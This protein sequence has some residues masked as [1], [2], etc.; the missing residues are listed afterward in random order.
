MGFC[1]TFFVASSARGAARL[2]HDMRVIYEGSIV[3]NVEF[4]YQ[5]TIKNFGLP[6]SIFAAQSGSPGINSDFGSP[7]KR[8]THEHIILT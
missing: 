1:W 5:T 7:D 3:I 2:M 4:D 6:E 8:I